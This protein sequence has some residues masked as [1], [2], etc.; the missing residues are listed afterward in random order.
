MQVS[1]WLT[2]QDNLNEK[3]GRALLQAMSSADNDLAGK[4]GQL[5]NLLQSQ[6]ALLQQ[7]RLNFA[8]SD[9]ASEKLA[10][11]I[12]AA[13]CNGV[14]GKGKQA[15]YVTYINTLPN[16]WTSARLVPPSFSYGPCGSWAKQ[17]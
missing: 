13:W 5:K 14:V 12:L 8:E 17:P 16:Q 10:R 4:L 7:D 1:Q 2:Q 3:L 11:A 9:A 6:P 15:Q